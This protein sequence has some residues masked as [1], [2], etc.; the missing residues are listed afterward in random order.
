M[1][2]SRRL[3]ALSVCAGTLAMTAS[4][5]AATDI[6]TVLPNTAAGNIASIGPANLGQSFVFSKD[7]VVYRYQPGFD[8]APTA[9]AGEPCGLGTH[10]VHPTPIVAAGVEQLT[11]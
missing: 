9:Y 5:S 11:T 4:A 1:S 8:S 7:C 10:T 3:V 2:L 6:S